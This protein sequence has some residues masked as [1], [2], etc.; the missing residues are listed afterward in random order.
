MAQPLGVVEADRV[1][2]PR[3]EFD[4]TIKREVRREKIKS[5]QV[6]PQRHGSIIRIS[7]KREPEGIFREVL[8]DATFLS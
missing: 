8:R 7:H 3:D 1:D 4:K 5:R 2:A 6:G